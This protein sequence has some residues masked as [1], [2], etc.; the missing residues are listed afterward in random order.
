[1]S[2]NSWL[3]LRG[4]R[5]PRAEIALL[6][7]VVIIVVSSILALLCAAFVGEYAY[8]MLYG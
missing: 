1:M 8:I 5:V 6:G 7:Y 4:I 2:L 3:A